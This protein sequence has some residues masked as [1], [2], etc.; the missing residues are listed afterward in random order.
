[1]A[2]KIVY[3]VHGTTT[4]NLEK[5]ATGWL[6]GELSEKGIEQANTLAEIIKDKHFDVVFSSDLHRAIQSAKI[7]FK[8]HKDISILSS[9]KIRECNY[10][11]YNGKDSVFADYSSHIEIPFPNGES[12]LDV[13]K[14]VREFCDYLKQN[15]D[16]KTV[17]LVSHKAPQLALDVI[18]NNKSWNQALKDDWRITKDWK[19]GWEY[20][21]N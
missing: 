2:V 16:K 17:A 7:D 20:I 19:P 15:Y 4:D 9:E 1:M 18:I 11:D 6:G 14:R 5:K 10:G 8:Y 3:F 21:L 12:L 13:E